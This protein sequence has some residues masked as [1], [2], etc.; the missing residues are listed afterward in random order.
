MLCAL[1][2]DS[3]PLCICLAGVVVIGL[4]KKFTAI[5][6][7]TIGAQPLANGGAIV[8]DA[9]AKTEWTKLWRIAVQN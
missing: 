1:P 5:G 8:T 9:F 2:F 6:A 4:K 7:G 3:L